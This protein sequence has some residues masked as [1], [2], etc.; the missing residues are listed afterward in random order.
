MLIDVLTEVAADTGLSPVDQRTTL[1]SILNRAAKEMFARLECNKIYWEVTLD[2]PPN[3][4]VTL[5][6]YI[7][8]LRGMRASTTEDVFPLKAMASPRYVRRDWSYRWHNWRDLGESA[9]LQNPT[10]VGPLTI[11]ASAPLTSDVNI[12]ISGQTNVALRIEEKVVLNFANQT[13]VTT[14]LFG[15]EIYN[16]ACVNSERD[17]DI[18]I[19]DANGNL[20]AVLYNMD[21]ATRY[22]MIDVSEAPWSLD[23]TDNTSLIDVLYKCKLRTLSKDSD[24]FPASADFDTAWYWMAMFLYYKP[25]QNKPEDF[26]TYLPQ[27]IM[28]MNVIKNGNE[29]QLEK[30]ISFGRNKFY[31][32]TKRYANS[33]GVYFINTNQ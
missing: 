22:K 1:L 5:P 7:Y 27:S 11:T 23:T 28:M 21:N 18:S 3:K 14:N 4:I 31:E 25:L 29:Q 2:V 10:L 8:E 19:S 20:L 26:N 30:K 9:V 15:P 16:I 6:S 32:L 12:L 24:C 17:C 33:A 13:K